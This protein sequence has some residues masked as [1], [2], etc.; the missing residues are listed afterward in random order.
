MSEEPP[1]QNRLRYRLHPQITTS[2]LKQPPKIVSI[3]KYPPISS[4]ISLSKAA[5]LRFDKLPR[6][7]SDL[8]KSTTVERGVMSL[9]VE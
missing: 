1:Y 3:L 7:A 8:R 9:A 6:A 5:P 4:Y 2:I